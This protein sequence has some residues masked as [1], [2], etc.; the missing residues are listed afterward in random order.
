LPRRMVVNASIFALLI[1]WAARRFVALVDWTREWL[2]GWLHWLEWLLWP[3]FVV[4]LILVAAYSFTLLANL[5]GAPFNGLLADATERFLNGEGPPAVVPRQRLSA[6]APRALAA[7]LDKL[8]Y[9]LRWAALVLLALLIPDVNLFVPVLWILLS[10]WMLA[11]EYFDYPLST[12]GMRP[13]QQRAFLGG[14]GAEAMSFGLG[15]VVLS[16]LPVVNFV[17]MPACVVGATALCVERWWNE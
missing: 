4:S 15:A 17:A 10:A 3:L 12:R 2:P 14:R 7:E 5:I 1:A 6:E 8:W 9:A 11:V 16:A 13:A